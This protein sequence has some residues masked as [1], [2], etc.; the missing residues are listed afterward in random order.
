[1]KNPLP[2]SRQYFW[3]VLLVLALLLPALPLPSFI[4]RLGTLVFIYASVVTSFNL[5]AGYCGLISVVQAGFF[6]IGAYTAAL[7]SVHLHTPFLANLVAGALASGVLSL[8]VGFATLKLKGRYLIMATFG[9]NEVINLVMVNS[10]FT[11]GPNGLPGV[12]PP[13]LFGFVFSSVPSLYYLNLAGLVLVTAV[14]AFVV[15]SPFGRS[16]VALREDEMAAE[17]I[18]V[19][20]ASTRLLA[21]TLAGGLAGLAGVFYAHNNLFVSYQTFTTDESFILL[22]MLV[23]G[24]LGTLPGPI[25]GV[26]VL[27]ALPEALRGAALYRYFIYGL[28]LFVVAPRWSGGLAGIRLRRKVVPTKRRPT[29]DVKTGRS[30]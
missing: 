18:G 4:I 29:L 10:E 2:G 24:G 5:L 16:M 15:N 8:L 9:I 26:A 22:A 3:Y 27:L 13:S 23:I 12:S 30:P 21:F 1:L 20:T 25:L 14:V 6:G 17:A 7:M 28:V 19:N 11:G